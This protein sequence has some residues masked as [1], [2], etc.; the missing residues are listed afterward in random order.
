MPAQKCL[1]NNAKAISTWHSFPHPQISAEQTACQTP[2]KMGCPTELADGYHILIAQAV[3]SA[4]YQ[5]DLFV[6]Q[7]Q[8]QLRGNLFL[9]SREIY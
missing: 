7:S 2:I 8:L 4:N 5:S 1:S 6:S 9:T 3:S